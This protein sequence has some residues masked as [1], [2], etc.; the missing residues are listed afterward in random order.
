MTSSKGKL[1]KVGIFEENFCTAAKKITTSQFPFCQYN[2]AL[3][4]T[5]KCPKVA[6]CAQFCLDAA[7]GRG[8][9]DL[10]QKL[11]GIF[12]AKIKKGKKHLVGL[13]DCIRTPIIV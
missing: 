13:M 10:G 7:N 1:T 5:A 3:L 11:D 9:R 6:E 12:N 2:L 4:D 8:D